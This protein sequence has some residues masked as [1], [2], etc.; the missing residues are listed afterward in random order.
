MSKIK[1]IVALLISFVVTTVSAQ[2]KTGNEEGLVWHTDLMEANKVSQAE[3]KPI[4]AFF[5]GSDWCG[6]CIRL[7]RNVFAKQAF[8]KWAKDSVVLLELDFPRKKKL[9]PKLAQQNY[10]LKKGFKVNGFPTIWFFTMVKDEATGQYNI[11]ALGS[12]GYPRGG[13][14]GKEED[15]FISDA[16]AILA[17]KN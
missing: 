9:A 17:N 10:R 14:K 6:W 11:S 12:T 1:I 5:T 2:Q 8:K 13:T 3:N 7:Q 4:F 16:N 15:K